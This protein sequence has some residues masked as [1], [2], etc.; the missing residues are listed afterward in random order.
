[1]IEAVGERRNLVGKRFIETQ[2]PPGYPK[3]FKI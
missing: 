2:K 1:M 3:A